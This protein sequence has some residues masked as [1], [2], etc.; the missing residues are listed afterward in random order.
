[1]MIKSGDTWN[2]IDHE[3]RRVVTHKHQE[4]QLEILKF[5]QNKYGLHLQAQNKR[6]HRE[7]IKA[8]DKEWKRFRR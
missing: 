8:M 7:G 6:N 5:K 2:I 4:H 1:M 3:K